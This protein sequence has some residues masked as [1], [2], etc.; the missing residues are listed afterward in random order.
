MTNT[1]LTLDA[2]S[3]K[4]ANDLFEIYSDPK[5]CKYFDMNPFKS[6][7]EAND[8]IKRWNSMKEDKKQIRDGIFYNKKL[9]GTC[10]IYAIYWHQKRA[11]LGFDLNSKYWNRGIITISLQE[12]LDKLKSE[13]NLHRIQATVLNDNKSS[14]RVLTKLGFNYEGVLKDY[15]K[16]KGEFVDLELYAKIL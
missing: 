10:G 8:H 15:E 3:L 9:I 7:D 1:S 5:V 11:T 4:H 16:W 12:L 14:I 13:Y 2:V 6:I